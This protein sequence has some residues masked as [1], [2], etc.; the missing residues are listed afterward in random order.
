MK[1]KFVTALHGDEVTP[2]LALSS[3]NA[4]QIVAN[5][6]ALSL[7]KRFIDMDMNKAFGTNGSSLEEKRA[8]EIL[9][10]LQLE[11]PDYVLDFHT[12]SA[13]T[14]PKMLN[15]AKTL[16]LN[17]IIL[18]KHNIK[19]GHALINHYNGVSVEA[20]THNSPE[21]FENVIRIVNS[22]TKGEKHTAILYEVYGLIETP[23]KY[24]NFVKHSDNFIPI[25]AGER[26]YDF[27]GLK[28][29][30]VNSFS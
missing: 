22:A 28:A 23:G 9:N 7:H 27:Y 25:L 1:I 10:Q 12:T 5:K 26:A 6:K 4:D 15:F 16:G 19:A 30:I 13:I 17:H 29:R 11:Q 2:V 18:M 14:D 20:G 8:D 21:A 3:I 24:I